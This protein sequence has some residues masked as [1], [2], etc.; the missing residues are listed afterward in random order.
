MFRF[1]VKLFF[2]VFQSSAKA[3]PLVRDIFLKCIMK[4]LQ[5]M[6]KKVSKLTTKHIL[7]HVRYLQT[8]TI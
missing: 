3:E 1:F 4:Q 6:L 7:V 5:C 2:V 8:L